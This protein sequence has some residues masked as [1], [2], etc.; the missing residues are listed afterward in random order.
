MKLSWLGGIQVVSPA[1]VIGALRGF[2]IGL[3]VLLGSSSGNFAWAEDIP[4]ASAEPLT[5]IELYVLYRDKTWNWD[6]G[7]VHFFDNGRRFLAWVSGDKG[8]SFG[9]GKFTLTDSGRLCLRGE[10]TDATGAEESVSCFLHKKD[11]GTI[12]QKRED[13][14]EWYIFRHAPVQA[15]DEINRLVGGDSVSDRVAGIKS[16]LGG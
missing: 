15:D 7:A 3:G 6:S 9:E 10:W 1:N 4:P 8:D 14:G 12:Y 2:A 5:A 16:K 11:R 13:E